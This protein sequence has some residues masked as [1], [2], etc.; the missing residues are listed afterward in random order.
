MTNKI[1]SR[2]L[3]GDETLNQYKGNFYTTATLGFVSEILQIGMEEPDNC[4]EVLESLKKDMAADAER[5]L[6][7][8]GITD[9]DNPEMRAYRALQE[10]VDR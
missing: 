5:R 8:D 9:E 2:L 3:E 6:R 1:H 10:I 4:K 7:E